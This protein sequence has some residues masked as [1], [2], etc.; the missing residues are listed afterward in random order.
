VS[1]L[2][3]SKA[4]IFHINIYRR[5]VSFEEGQIFAKKNG[6]MFFE[7]SAKTSHNVEKAFMSTA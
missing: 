3:N 7:T 2:I 6:L 5:E 1:L 4:E